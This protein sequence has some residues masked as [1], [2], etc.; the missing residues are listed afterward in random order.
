MNQEYFHVGLSKSIY[1]GLPL[2]SIDKLIHLESDNICV[3]PGVVS[4]W[5]GLFN[6]RGSLV[7]IIDTN[8]FLT[9]ASEEELMAKKQTLLVLNPQIQEGQK[10]QIALMVK[11]L[12]GILTLDKNQC[13]SSC[14]TE[15]L[16]SL[17]KKICPTVVEEENK[18]IYLLDTNILLEQIYQNSLLSAQSNYF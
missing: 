5:A 12:A 16:S 18:Q 13:Q 6:Y 10:K 11:N 2:N 9:V 15:A 4:F 1:L 7:W 8:K 17:G 3:S 14:A